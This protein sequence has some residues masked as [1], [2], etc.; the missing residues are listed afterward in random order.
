MKVWF[1]SFH[2]VEESMLQVYW[3]TTELLVVQYI[4]STNCL[5]YHQGFHVHDKIE[6]MQCPLRKTKALRILLLHVWS[7]M[8]PF[9]LKLRI[10]VL[11]L[12]PMIKVTLNSTSVFIKVSDKSFFLVIYFKETRFLCSPSEESEICTV[13]S[14]YNNIC[15]VIPPRHAPKSLYVMWYLIYIETE[16]SGWYWASLFHSNCARPSLWQAIGKITLFLIQIHTIRRLSTLYLQAQK[17]LLA[18]HG[19]ALSSTSKAFQKSTK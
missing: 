16:E 12:L 4:V 17:G 8:P 7:C 3:T 15:T 11:M 6:H 5:Q 19:W 1:R 9:H 14:A 13:S 2:L 10:R 18:L